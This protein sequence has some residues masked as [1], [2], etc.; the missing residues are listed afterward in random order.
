[1]RDCVQRGSAECS[2]VA[3]DVCVCALCI[4]FKDANQIVYTFFWSLPLSF[5]APSLLL[6]S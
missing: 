6:F 5:S 2:D 3:Y 4:A 1:M